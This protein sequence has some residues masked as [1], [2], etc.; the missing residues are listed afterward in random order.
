[1]MDKKE[2]ETKL[3]SCGDFV[4]MDYLS[5]CLKSGKLD[6]DTKKFVMVRLSG[7][8]EAR[9]MFYD[10]GR[11]LLHASD[12]NPTEQGRVT[13]YVKAGEL[14]VKGGKFEEAEIAFNKALALC[15]DEKRKDIV[16]KARIESMIVQAKNYL[17][18]GKRK[19]A[20]DT[21]EKLLEFD[22]NPDEKREIRERVLKLYEKLG[23]VKEYMKLKGE[24]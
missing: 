5:R 24:I 21:Y 19:H 13:D 15:P 8:Y 4:K 2:I 9:R 6:L 14:F 23:M 1:M 17:R 12:I 22:V 18:K 16:K 3:A 7:I 10:A 20:L 11:L